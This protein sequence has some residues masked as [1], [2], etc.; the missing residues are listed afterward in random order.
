MPMSNPWRP[1]SFKLINGFLNPISLSLNEIACNQETRPVEPIVTM[2]ANHGTGLAA[3]V[4]LHL[5]RDLSL[6]PIDQCDEIACLIGRGRNLGHCWV[7]VV[8]DPALLH[9]SWV[10]DWVLVA[11]V[12]HR[13]DAATVLLREANR[14]VLFVD[15][16]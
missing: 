13:V 9:R 12:N 5:V 7:L 14:V 2:H 6:K 4:L 10:V 8:M 16:S 15:F 3:V 1:L 11:D